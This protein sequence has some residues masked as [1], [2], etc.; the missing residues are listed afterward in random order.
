[1]TATAPTDVL[2]RTLRAAFPHGQ[3]HHRASVT[4][5]MEVARAAVEAGAPEGTLILAD[6]Q[7]QG[8]G[9]RGRGWASPPG[10]LWASLILTP[11]AS[12][13]HA[14]CFSV[15][16][17]VGL[18]Q[19]LRDRFGL[20][21]AVKWPNDLLI[22]GRKLGGTLIELTSQ[23]EQLAWLIVGV[24]LNVNNAPPDDA[25]VPATSLR[26]ELGT[27]VEIY[28]AATTLIDG[29]AQAYGTFQRSGFAP[30]KRDWSNVSALGEQVWIV[31]NDRAE[32]V[33]AMGLADDGRLIVRDDEGIRHLAS[34]EI[35]L[36][37]E[38]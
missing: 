22:H 24:G 14:G 37:L 38:A 34:E 30:I 31:Q 28:D 35:T 33:Q 18:A 11:R 16:V 10:G 6:E 20:P 23:N 5:T 26:R 21:I 15:L 32:R 25:R 7:R 27:D 13:A 12:D 19:A 3:I 17:A 4:S 2:K 9:R 1:M 29:V 8:R 36:E